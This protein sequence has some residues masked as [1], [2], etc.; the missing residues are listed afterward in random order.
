MDKEIKVQ[1]LQNKDLRKRKFLI[2]ET[3]LIKRYVSLHDFEDWK[4]EMEEEGFKVVI[5]D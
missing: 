1:F 5:V 4:K 3:S 2:V